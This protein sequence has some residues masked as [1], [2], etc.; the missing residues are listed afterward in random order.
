[1]NK[2]QIRAIN[3]MTEVPRITEFILKYSIGL[4][5]KSIFP[6]F[7]SRMEVG[8][9][10]WVYVSLDLARGDCSCLQIKHS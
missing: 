10:N 8:A 5:D 9:F 2:G 7:L 1:M 3:V 6:W 4:D